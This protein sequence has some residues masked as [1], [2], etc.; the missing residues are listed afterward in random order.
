MSNL[1]RELEGASTGALPAGSTVVVAAAVMPDDLA[2][3]LLRLRGDGH[4]V[5]VVKTS[6]REWDANLGR[7]PVT[8]VSAFMASQE[9]ATALELAADELVSQQEPATGGVAA[10]V[11]VV[12]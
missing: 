1:A 6:E 12:G 11:A 4:F 7:I 9:A 5:H 8:D 2:A 10:D 3:T